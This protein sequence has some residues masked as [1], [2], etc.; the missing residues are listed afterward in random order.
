[1]NGLRQDEQTD[2]WLQWADEIAHEVQV[3]KDGYALVDLAR[4]KCVHQGKSR[5]WRPADDVERAECEQLQEQDLLLLPN[6]RLLLL[7]TTHGV[8]HPTRKDQMSEND[9]QQWQRGIEDP[10]ESDQHGVVRVAW[11]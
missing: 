7:Q 6:D 5:C 2:Q 4:E 3:S 11:R 10:I 8:E 9:R 1:M